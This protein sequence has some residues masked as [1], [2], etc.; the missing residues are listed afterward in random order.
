MNRTNTG[1]RLDLAH[2]PHLAGF[3]FFFLAETYGMRDP[4]SLTRDW[5]H[6]PYCGSTVDWLAL[7]QARQEKFIF[8]PAS[9][10]SHA[11]SKGQSDQFSFSNVSWIPYHHWSPSQHH[12]P[13]E[14]QK[15]PPNCNS[16]LYSC[17]TQFSARA[18][19]SLCELDYVFIPLPKTF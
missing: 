11:E 2:E 14:A 9:L 3:F 16:S 1:A 7:A 13:R 6:V 18:K 15:Q 12:L 8:A 10:P 4:S 19:T 5:T 17:S